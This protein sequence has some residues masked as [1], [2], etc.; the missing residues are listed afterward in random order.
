M[1]L[2]DRAIVKQGT[3][4]N[5]TIGQI[6]GSVLSSTSSGAPPV[7][8]RAAG[9]PD[10]EWIRVRP[11]SMWRQ[12]MHA[13]AVQTVNGK[14]VWLVDHYLLKSSL[15]VRH[16]ELSQYWV[17]I[18]LTQDGYL[19]SWPISLFGTNRM[20]SWRRYA[21]E[22]VEKAQRDWVFARPSTERGPY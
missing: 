20:G 14:R 10:G 19:F 11:G 13:I 8:I 12:E 15:L 5:G 6:T 22:V 21:L 1:E 3:D 4:V 17:F 2:L 18:S 16:G 9:E 7:F